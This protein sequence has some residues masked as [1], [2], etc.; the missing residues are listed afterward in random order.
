M[1]LK[2]V[3]RTQHNRHIMSVYLKTANITYPSFYTSKA[4]ELSRFNFSLQVGIPVE[5]TIS[6]EILIHKMIRFQ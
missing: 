6:S 5:S 4:S 2:Y 1:L 3:A